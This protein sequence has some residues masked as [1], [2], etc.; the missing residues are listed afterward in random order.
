MLTNLTVDDFVQNLL[1]M[2]PDVEIIRDSVYAS[3]STLDAQR[4]AD[5]Y[6]R[7]RK[8][9]DKGIIEPASTNGVSGVLAGGESKSGNAGGW[10]EVA[11]KGPEK[12]E[13]SSAQFK[14]VA[15]KK[16]GKR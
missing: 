7:R 8:L 4:I 2:P 14:V 3:S 15:G 5:E 10:S 13:E 6:I 16:K 11:R 12:K 1:A 9:A